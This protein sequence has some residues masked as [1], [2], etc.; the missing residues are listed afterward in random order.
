[1]RDS[2]TARD[3]VS[4]LPLTLTLEDYASTEK[5]SDLPKRLS[6]A[7]APSGSDPCVGDIAFYAPWGNLA[8]FY[9]DAEYANALIVLGK[10]DG[11]TEAF[12]VP[13]SVKVTIESAK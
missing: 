13:G 1:L 12:S 4:Q 5:I 3:F 6:T 9:R 7:G 11:D 8:I 2:R 10:L